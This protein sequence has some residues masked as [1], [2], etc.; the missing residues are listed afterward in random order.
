MKK[1]RATNWVVFV[2]L[3]FTAAV[4][5]E[6]F[7]LID[8]Q[9]LDVIS[10]YNNGTLL[11]TST[12]DV[13]EGGSI[14]IAYVYD[15]SFLSVFGGV[16]GSVIAGFYDG[17]DYFYPG[18][19]NVSGGNVGK[20]N[21]RY[22]GTVNISGGNVSGV[23][24]FYSN[25]SISNG[26]VGYLKAEGFHSNTNVSGGDVSSIFARGGSNVG[27]S[28]GSVGS[29]FVT[30]G[31]GIGISGGDVDSI[32]F[33]N[34]SSLSI[35]NGNVGYVYAA[36]EA[37]SLNISGGN[38]VTVDVKEGHVFIDGGKVTNLNINRLENLTTVN[39]GGVGTVETLYVAQLD[40]SENVFCYSGLASDLASFGVQAADGAVCNVEI[41]R[42]YAYHQ[43]LAGISGGSIDTLYAMDSSTI[44]FYGQTF[45]LGN[46]LLLNGS[47]LVGT[48]ILSG[49]WIDGTY[50]QTNIAV[51]DITSTILLIPEPASLL[52]LAL[53]GLGVRKRKEKRRKV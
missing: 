44:T 43:T 46:G 3:L 4:Q 14:E 15:D 17:H 32:E 11:K 31:C 40:L 38:A 2:V 39:I 29:V 25:V 18:N 48:G 1:V 50:W 22:G 37:G 8:S 26:S 21:V 12:A 53:G 52:L 7:T 47:Q 5:A 41:S 49:Q 33:G 27:I 20:L 6:D 16:I 45:I 42:L 30:G 13:F 28:S 51:N 10:G 19:V 24:N 9:H 34:A 36:G 35:S 23:D